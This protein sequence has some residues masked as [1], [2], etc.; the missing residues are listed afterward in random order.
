MKSWFGLDE[1]A[2]DGLQ[3]GIFAEGKWIMDG[4]IDGIVR[5][6]AR[7]VDMGDGVTS[8]AGDPGSGRRVMLSIEPR[9]VKGAAEEGHWIMAAGAKAGGLH[10]AVAL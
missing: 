1:L 10:I 2:V 3:N 7:A 8:A 6:A 9:I 4:F 5:V